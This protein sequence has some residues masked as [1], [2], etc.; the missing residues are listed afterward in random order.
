MHARDRA[1]AGQARRADQDPPQRGRAGPVRGRADL[2]E[3]QR[4]LR[5]PA[6]DD[7]GH[8]ERRPPLRARLPAAREAVRRRQRLRQAQQL[9]DG[10]RHGHQPA[11]AGRHA[12]REPAVPVLLRGRHQ[13]RQQA[14]GSCCA[15]RWPTPA[16]TTASAP[17]RR[18]RRSSRSSSAPSSRRSFD[19][20]R[21]RLGRRGHAAGLPGDGRVGAPAPADARR[22]PQ[23]HL[24]VRL[25]RQQVRV[26]RARLVDVAR[27]PNTVLNTIVAEAIDA[28]RRRS[29]R[30][31]S[32]GGTSLEEAVL[33]IVKDSLD[34]ATSG[35]CSPAT[36]TPTSGTP[37]PS[38]AAWPTCASRRT[39]CRG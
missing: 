2:R 16:R 5:P 34:G 25:H 17:T 24:A 1:R 32:T 4:R 13:G 8:A 7:A 38:S 11:R 12:A 27:L 9:V 10:H 20:D 21:V 30:R 22:R 19:G 6:A 36:T 37:R 26:P 15:R 23:P 3:L 28:P 31:P 29:S 33:A 35:S 39:R 14:P 18:R